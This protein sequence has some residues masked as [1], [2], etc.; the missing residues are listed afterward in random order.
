MERNLSVTPSQPSICCTENLIIT[1]LLAIHGQLQL[2]DFH[3]NPMCRVISI[4][5]GLF[6]GETGSAANLINLG[7]LAVGSF[8]YDF[9]CLPKQGVNQCHVYCLKQYRQCCQVCGFPTVYF[10]IQYLVFFFLF[11]QCSF[12]HRLFM[13]KCLMKRFYLDFAKTIYTFK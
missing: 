9:V 1:N 2:S 8:A 5:P 12:I 7:Q 6:C 4:T 11:S 13:T 10:V 3:F